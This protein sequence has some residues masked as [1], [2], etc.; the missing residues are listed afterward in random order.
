MILAII[1]DRLTF[2]AG[3]WLD[4]R[5]RAA[6][7]ARRPLGHDRRPGGDR[8][9]SG[10][11]APFVIDATAFPD[12]IAFSFRTPVNEFTSWLTDTF[13]GI[14]LADQGHRDRVVINPLEGFLTSSPWWL[15]I[16]IVA[17]IAWA[18]LRPAAGDHRGGLPR[19]D[20]RSSASGSTRWRR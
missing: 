1:L 3:E 14:T 13:Q 4:P 10:L 2:A 9:G 11:P 5:N 20:R 8:S 19:P 17:L 15:V 6:G 16:A 12:A 18:D 7:P